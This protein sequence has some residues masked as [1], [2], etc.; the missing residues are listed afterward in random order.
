MFIFNAIR[1]EYWSKPFE[2]AQKIIITKLPKNPMDV[3]SY[4]LI[5]LLPTISKVIE[6]LVFSKDLKPPHWIPDHQFGFRQAHSTV[7]HCHRITDVTSSITGSLHSTT[8]SPHNRRDVINNK[9]T[10]QCNNVTA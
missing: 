3:S 5:S 9:L 1:L 10:P 2:I 4:R 6:K 8:M 7:Q